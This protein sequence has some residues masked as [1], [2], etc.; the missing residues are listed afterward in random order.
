MKH[1]CDRQAEK[2]ATGSAQLAE[3]Y[4]AVRCCPSMRG[5]M[6]NRA[7][8]PPGT[9][10]IGHF[11]PEDEACQSA[12]WG[13]DRLSHGNSVYSALRRRFR[14]RDEAR[15]VGAAAG[16]H[17]ELC[18]L[19]AVSWI[20]TA[21]SRYEPLTRL[22]CI[23]EMCWILIPLSAASQGFGYIAIGYAAR[24]TLGRCIC[25]TLENLS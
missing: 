21:N 1:A 18:A 3:Y 13:S 5:W 16:V 12:I 14:A 4:A 9:E 19:E 20:P 22:E 2:L 7:G 24:D 17:E 23:A 15:R 11:L 25:N 10:C 6:K 8:R